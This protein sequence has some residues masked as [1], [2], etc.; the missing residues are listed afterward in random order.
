MV[1]SKKHHRDTES[2]ERGAQRGR[3]KPYS[4]CKTSVS[5]VPPWFFPKKLTTETQRAQRAQRGDTEGL[6][7]QDGVHVAHGLGGGMEELFLLVVEGQLDDFLY[8]VSA[9][10]SGYTDVNVMQVVLPL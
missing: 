9:E 8:A 5:S 6:E 1:I 3:T 10:F 2:T 4:L 7:F